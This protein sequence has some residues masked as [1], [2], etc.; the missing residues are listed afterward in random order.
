MPNKSLGT[1]TLD[2]IVETGGFESGMDAA[3]RSADKKTRQ[4]EQQTIARAKAIEMAMSSM[5]KSIA[6]PLAGAAIGLG[7]IKSLAALRSSIDDTI[8]GFADLKDAAEKTGASVSNL[9]GLKGVAKIGGHDFAEVEGALVRLNKALHGTD[10]ESKGAGKALAALGLDL[11]KLRDMDPAEAMLELAQAQESFADGGGKSAA[12]MAILGKNGAQLIPYLKDLAEQGKLVG[13]VTTEQALAAD[14]YEKNIKRLQ[15]AW[16]G[17]SK[18]MA[19]AVVGPARDVTDWMVKAQKEGGALAAVFAG[20]GMAMAKAV[21]VEINPL[22]RAENNANEAFEKLSRLKHDLAVWEKSLAEGKGL[23]GLLGGQLAKKKIAETKAEIETTEKALK[24]AITLK[25]SLVS[26][27][28]ADAEPKSTALN[29]Q[30]FG[31]EAK[32]PKA[33]DPHA[34]DYSKT[35]QSLNEKISVQT[36]D[37]LSIEKLTQ[38]QKDY[39]KFQ[40]DIASG[41]TVL[42][43]AQKA[44]AG[45]YWQVYLARAKQNDLEKA[46]KKAGLL[47]DDYKRAN[48][49]IL[50]RIGREDELAL[51]TQRSLAI[52]QALYKVEDDGKA[53]RERIIRDIEDETTQKKALALADEELAR[54]R[55]KVASATGQSYDAQNSF[56]FGWQKAF[57]AYADDAGNAAK[58]AQNAFQS[59]TSSLEDA[60]VQFTTNTKYSF[61]DMEQSILKSLAQIAAKQAAM[62]LIKLGTSL[63]ASGASASSSAGASTTPGY[64]AGDLGSGIRVNALGNVFQSPSL[65]QY[66]NQIHDT[67]KFFAFAKGGVLGEAGPEAIMPLSRGANG[68]LGVRADGVGSGGGVTVNVNV[69]VDQS[70]NSTHETTSTG[71]G[72][73]SA[74]V[75]K[76]LGNMIAAGAKRVIVDEMRSGGMLAG[77][78]G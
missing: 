17:L 77:V 48:A 60:M 50:E 47:V 61:K 11:K 24:S 46:D 70:G 64:S 53:I 55:D 73:G 44:V 16:G 36:E 20:L 68:K 63:F 76:Q 31:T 56:S 66:A 27:T 74:D 28:A 5:A 8:S 69:S 3:A 12:M 35:I 42:T 39:A 14:E 32:T 54:Q 34:N 23:D 13:K 37:L 51:V 49:Q 41:A 58:T 57:N 43:D 75:F 22:Q 10:D 59:V 72:A 25:N 6:A 18:Q 40:A 67:P 21:G 2:L 26:K 29:S 71:D 15:G 9:S 78:K 65:H 19:A 33:T 30:N 38:A 7:S 62:G 45:A 4:I 1:L 52:A